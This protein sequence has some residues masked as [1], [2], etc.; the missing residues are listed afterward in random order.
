MNVKG[1]FPY[2]VSGFITCVGLFFLAAGFI[3][4]PYLEAEPPGRHVLLGLSIFFIVVGLLAAV[5]VRQG[6]LKKVGITVVDVRK[7][8]ISKLSDT[9]LLA[10]IAMEDESRRVRDAAAE[11][12]KEIKD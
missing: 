5:L 1:Y 12:L 3:G 7:E 9:Q 10:K 8:T 4:G 2:L 11:R 6:K